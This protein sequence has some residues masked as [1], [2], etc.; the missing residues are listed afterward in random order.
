[1]WDQWW[2]QARKRKEAEA[3]ADRD[4]R[5][6]KCHHRNSKHDLKK[7]KC[8]KCRDKKNRGCAPKRK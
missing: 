5:C 7:E 8:R 3:K 1:M 2:Y 6:K 4:R